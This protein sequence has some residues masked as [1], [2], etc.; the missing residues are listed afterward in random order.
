[1]RVDIYVKAI[2]RDNPPDSDNLVAKM[3]IDGLRPHI[4]NDDNNKWVRRVIT[5]AERGSE[6]KVV[7]TVIPVT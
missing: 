4:I 6:N 3:V 1:V 5:E 2:Y 7:V